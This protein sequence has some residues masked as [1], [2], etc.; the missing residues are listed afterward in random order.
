MEIKFL[1]I[2][3]KCIY[4]QILIYSFLKSLETTLNENNKNYIYYFT[5]LEI[6]GNIFNIELNTLINKCKI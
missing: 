5:L 6:F 3:N 2:I 4:I 1:T